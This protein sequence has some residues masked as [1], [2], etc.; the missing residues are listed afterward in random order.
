MYP[1][2]TLLLEEGEAFLAHNE[3]LGATE[4]VGMRSPSY[5]AGDLRKLKLVD[6][7]T[8]GQR[9]HR[10]SEPK[11]LPQALRRTPEQ[12]LK[13]FRDV[14][15]AIILSA[16]GKQSEAGKMSGG[17]Y[18]GDMA[19]TCWNEELV[20]HVQPPEAHDNTRYT[21]QKQQAEQ[22]LFWK[23][24]TQDRLGYF[25]NFRFHQKHLG[26]LS[27]KLDMCIDAY[28]FTHE[29]TTDLG[30]AAFLQVRFENCTKWLLRRNN[31][32]FLTNTRI[33]FSGR[34]TLQESTVKR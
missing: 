15:N 30:R 10:F 19:W 32:S 17:D 4:V 5:F 3:A 1:D 33:F 27:E 11:G 34:R 21:V 2:H 28:G 16:R 24:T 8:L 22:K 18:D 12:R 14:R 31:S 7:F 13:F 9:A 23:T 25:F 26:Y 20:S 29:F 6:A